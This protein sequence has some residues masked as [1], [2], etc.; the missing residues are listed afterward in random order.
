MQTYIAL[1][2]GINVSGH[3]KIKMPELKAMFE[4]LGFTNVRTYIQSGNV[5]F[6][7]E[8]SEDLESKISAKI[9]EQFGFEVSV[10]CRTSA[11]MKQVI[12]RNPFEK[13]VGFEPEKLYITFLQQTPSAEKLEALQAFTFEPEMYT[14]SGKEIY[15]YCFNGYGNTKLENAFFEKKLKVAATTRNWRTVN[16]L[17]EMSQPETTAN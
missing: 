15:V 9:Q 1:L 14:V 8:T 11:E 13:M 12:A 3:K 5:V 16:K 7:S 17:I 10:I 6:E 4:E 2:R